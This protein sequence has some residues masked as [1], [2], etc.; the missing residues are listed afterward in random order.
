MGGTRACIAEMVREAW[1]DQR[2][3]CFDI[4]RL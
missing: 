4:L 3:I 2:Q 1:I